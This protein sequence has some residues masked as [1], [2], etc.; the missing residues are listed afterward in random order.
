MEGAGGRGD[1][2]EGEGVGKDFPGQEG[3]EGGG[4]GC[5]WLGWCAWHGVLGLGFGVVFLVLLG[6]LG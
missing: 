3:E 4:L 6:L 2:E 5:W 1:E